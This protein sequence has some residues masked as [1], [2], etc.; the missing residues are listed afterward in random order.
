M[1]FQIWYRGSPDKRD[2]G[3]QK[4]ANRQEKKGES[5]MENKSLEVAALIN[6][7]DQVPARIVHWSAQTGTYKRTFFFLLSYVYAYTYIYIYLEASIRF[8]CMCRDTSVAWERRRP[9]PTI[10]IVKRRRRRRRSS[11]RSVRAPLPFLLARVFFSPRWRIVRA[12]VC[13]Y[14]L[15]CTCACVRAKKDDAFI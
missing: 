9:G 12:C 3:A 11:S 5:L 14:V 8:G 13:A 7:C 2:S 10:P 1:I 6:A 4:R 15:V